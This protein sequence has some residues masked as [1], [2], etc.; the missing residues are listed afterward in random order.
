MYVISPV[1]DN[2]PSW[3]I[4]MKK[5]TVEDFMITW[6]TVIWSNWDSN[7]LSL[8]L[9]SGVLPTALC[10]ANI[11]SFSV[12]LCVVAVA[13]QDDNSSL[14]IRT[15]QIKQLFWSKPE[16]SMASRHQSKR[17]FQVQPQSARKLNNFSCLY[18]WLLVHIFYS[19]CCMKTVFRHISIHSRF[20]SQT[21]LTSEA[22]DIG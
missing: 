7:L 3:I 5:M 14:C 19:G 20:I 9:Q 2:C 8:D 13:I 17:K 1:A 16:D 12:P 22:Y 11:V 15:G 18:F 21:W 4:R 10:P 6:T